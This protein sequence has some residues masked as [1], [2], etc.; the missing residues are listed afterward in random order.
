[1]NRSSRLRHRWDW[2]TN[3][4]DD[5]QSI[6]R[7]KLMLL[8]SFRCLSFPESDGCQCQPIYSCLPMLLNALIAL[9]WESTPIYSF[10]NVTLLQTAKGR[11]SWRWRWWVCI[12]E[13][14]KHP[15]AIGDSALSYSISQPIGGHRWQAEKST[16]IVVQ[17]SETSRRQ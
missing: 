6:H 12:A 11:Q 4:S 13:D 3:S 5:S 10:H 1:M 9:C 17:Q 2:S 16:N 8:D 7:H 14:H 15:T